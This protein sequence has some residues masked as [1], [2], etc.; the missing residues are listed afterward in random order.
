MYGNPD[1]KKEKKIKKLNQKSIKNW[2]K[3]K[4]SY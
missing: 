4:K 2:E 3:T 1:V